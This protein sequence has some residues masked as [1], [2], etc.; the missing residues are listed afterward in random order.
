MV[1][2]SSISNSPALTAWPSW[3]WMARTTPVSN[4]CTPL[5]RPVGTILPGAVAMMSTEP[6]LAQ[7]SAATKNRMMVPAMARPA[8]EAGVSMIS[9]AAGRNS[10]SAP[11]RAGERGHGR[12]RALP[13]ADFMDAGL[14]TVQ[15]GVAP[16]GADELVVVVI[17]DDAAALDR[18]DAVGAAHGREAMGDDQH[19]AV[20]RD[21]AHVLLDDA[22]A[23]VI[24]RAGRLVEDQDARIGD[25]GAGDGDAL[26]LPARQARA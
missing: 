1:V 22:L 10:S 17:L 8:G 5:L 9:S 14:Q 7:A 16:A 26:A 13:S 6:R 21:L 19:G 25:E 12:M 2:S 24:E 23:L 18:D 20:L 4:G 15:R 3:T 11:L